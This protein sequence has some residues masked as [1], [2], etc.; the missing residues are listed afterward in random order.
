MNLNERR[1]DRA[2]I[3]LTLY[4]SLTGDEPD[5]GNYTAIT[6][7]VADILHLAARNGLDPASILERAEFTHEGDLEDGPEAEDRGA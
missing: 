3:L 7:L 4:L 2:A 5:A 1:A 6:D